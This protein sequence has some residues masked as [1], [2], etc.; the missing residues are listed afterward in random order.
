MLAKVVAVACVLLLSGLSRDTLAPVWPHEL[1]LQ[2]RPT[3]SRGEMEREAQLIRATLGAA[4]NAGRF[5]RQDLENFKQQWQSLRPLLI[6][7]PPP[8]ADLSG[9]PK[10]V[11]KIKNFLWPPR[12]DT[13]EFCAT[14]R[15]A[16]AAY[17]DQWTQ[18]RTLKPYNMC[19]TALRVYQGEVGPNLAL[20]V[21]RRWMVKKMM[22]GPRSFYVVAITDKIKD[23]AEFKAAIRNIE[24]DANLILD[25]RHLGPKFP[26]AEMIDFIPKNFQKRLYQSG[27]A[28]ARVIGLW[29]QQ[30]QTQLQMEIGKTPVLASHFTKAD[31]NNERRPLL[32][33]INFAGTGRLRGPL[34]ILVDRT[35]FR[36]CEDF[37]SM[38]QTR[39]ATA[40]VGQNTPGEV[41]FD[42]PATSG[43][44]LPYSHIFLQ[45][46]LNYS[47]L[48]GQDFI[49]LQ[50]QRPKIRVE[51]GGDAWQK[52]T[53]ILKGD[54]D[55]NP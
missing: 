18:V 52:L 11:A 27:Q 42:P 26:Y 31:I 13:M 35:C 23:D 9:W 43:M 21:K 16:L 19:G 2:V 49:E 40:L 37:L 39:P 24:P 34:W 7:G 41:H 3:I 36:E 55:L 29:H 51:R 1:D 47:E 15:Q 46:N 5:Y 44:L 53:Q 28:M 48:P 10:I 54:G 32:Q 8:T 20:A 38:L 17:P 25:L 6:K 12:I 30:I 4:T 14:L 50:G 22:L 45:I 33:T